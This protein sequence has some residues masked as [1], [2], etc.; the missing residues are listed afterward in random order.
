MKP[1][2]LL[3]HV[4]S[5]RLVAVK[6]QLKGEFVLCCWPGMDKNKPDVPQEQVAALHWKELRT[7]TAAEKEAGHAAPTETPSTAGDVSPPAGS[8]GKAD[9]EN[10]PSHATAEH[11]HKRKR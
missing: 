9:I 4:P 5:G 1:G 3:I 10:E 2:D 7:A 8:D 6:E 11:G